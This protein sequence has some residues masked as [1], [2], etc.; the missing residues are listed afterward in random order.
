MDNN[1]IEIHALNAE[2]EG[3]KSANREAF[4]NGDTQP[5]SEFKFNY[6]ANEIRKCKTDKK[7]KK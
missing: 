7:E 4:L 2:I 1:T 5:Y 3:M 6:V